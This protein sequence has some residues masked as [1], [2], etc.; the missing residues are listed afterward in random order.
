MVVGDSLLSDSTR[1]EGSEWRRVVTFS[2]D[3]GL[4]VPGSG[5]EVLWATGVD[6]AGLVGNYYFKVECYIDKGYKVCRWRYGS[7]VL[8]MEF[9]C[10]GGRW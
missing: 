9:Y 8:C 10:E 4:L 7:W 1:Y 6:L 3:S 2:G 5:Y